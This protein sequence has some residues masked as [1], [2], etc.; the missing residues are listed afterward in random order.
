MKS[1]MGYTVFAIVC[2]VETIY[3][4]HEFC[5]RG[6]QVATKYHQCWDS[7]TYEHKYT[8]LY[9]AHKD[10]TPE[11]LQD[12]AT[13]MCSVVKPK[14]LECLQKEVKDCSNAAKLVAIAN[15]SGGAC[16]GNHLNPFFKL[17]IIDKLKTVNGDSPCF[18]I[19]DNSYKCYVMAGDVIMKSG[20][21]TVDIS[22]FHRVADKFFGIIWDC[23]IDVFKTNSSMCE[24]WQLPMLLALQKTAMPSLFGM[25]LNNYQVAKLELE[26]SFVIPTTTPSVIEDCKKGTYFILL[27]ALLDKPVAESGDLVL[28]I[29]TNEDGKPSITLASNPKDNEDFAAF[30]DLVSKKDQRKEKKKKEKEIKNFVQRIGATQKKVKTERKLP[31]RAQ[32]FPKMDDI[33]MIN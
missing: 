19:A 10:Y 14:A 2:F 9:V 5:H 30:V 11:F 27:K 15:E 23:L 32:K 1:S 26:D 31:P 16:E 20:V 7:A 12:Y 25:R 3:G 18:T 29:N 33:G 4:A 22:K 24:Q 21:D 8:G 13:H 17:H 6:F 28:E